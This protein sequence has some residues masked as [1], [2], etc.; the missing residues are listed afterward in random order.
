M[1]TEI[2]RHYA[3]EFF[4]T[5]CSVYDVLRCS[6]N[7]CVFNAADS[8]YAKT[9]QS[10]YDSIEVMHDRAKKWIAIIKNAH[11]SSFI[12][13][14]DGRSEGER[15]IFKDVKL[16][17]PGA[18][19][20]LEDG[21]WLK[22]LAASEF[23]RTKENEIAYYGT[24]AIRRAAAA[25]KASFATVQDNEQLAMRRSH[26]QD[27]VL[28]KQVDDAA[29]LHVG[30]VELGDEPD[31]REIQLL[32]L[33]KRIQ[34]R[35]I[36]RLMSS[37]SS[38]AR[39]NGLKTD[40]ISKIASLVRSNFKRTI[41]MTRTR[42]APSRCRQ[43]TGM[44]CNKTREKY[45]AIPLEATGQVFT[46]SRVSVRG[47]K[48][49]GWGLFADHPFKKG[50]IVAEYIGEYVSD[51]VADLREKRY[52]E[53]RIQ[54]YMFR[55]DG[56]FVSNLVAFYCFSFRAIYLLFTHKITYFLSDVGY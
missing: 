6:I 44:A 48:I 50:Q 42:V 4:L 55:I 3:N 32:K 40:E 19:E 46:E 16:M 39:C 52:R 54:D 21:E 49:H 29:A 23:N 51:A 9:A 1:K 26:V 17:W 47:S 45:A 56:S 34:K 10:I 43:S 22:S 15:D 20:L 18:I 24:L 30:P 25:A 38:C 37:E 41:D 2:A 33:L 8:L 27:E 36:E 35:R 13:S 12:N 11:A 53:R 14:E 28:R 31:W 5:I 7:A